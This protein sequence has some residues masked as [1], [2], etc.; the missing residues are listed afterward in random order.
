MLLEFHLIAEMTVKYIDSRKVADYSGVLAEGRE[1][2][3][4]TNDCCP[5]S[6]D[7]S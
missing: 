7:G 4:E 2:C 1:M 5:V 3:Q 6:Q